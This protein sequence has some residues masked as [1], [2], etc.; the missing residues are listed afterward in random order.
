[1]QHLE[2][3]FNFPGQYQVPTNLAWMRSWI[4]TEDNLT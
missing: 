3:D 4:I 2:F 1:M